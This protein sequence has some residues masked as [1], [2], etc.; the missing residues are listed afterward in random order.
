MEL[1]LEH[2][3]CAQI[4][5]FSDSL[6]PLKPLECDLPML[7]GSEDVVAAF[8]LPFWAFLSS[9]CLKFGGPGDSSLI[10]L[11]ERRTS[12]V[13]LP[14]ELPEWLALGEISLD[15]LRLFE[16]ALSIGVSDDI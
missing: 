11:R 12:V 14:A 5:L 1:S 9:S 2:E 10:S 7:S 13:E 4:L 16:E 6:P 15:E 3:D 8:P